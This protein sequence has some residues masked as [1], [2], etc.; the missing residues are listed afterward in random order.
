[1]STLRSD[2]GCTVVVE[3]SA[4]QAAGFVGQL[5][6]VVVCE[7][8][9]A[10]GQCSVALAGGTTPYLL[11]QNLASCGASSE[12]PWGAVNFFFGDERDVP[13]DHLE[14]NY[15]MAQ[16]ALLDHVP[17]DPTRIHPMRADSDDLA[18]AAAEYEKSIR[19]IVPSEGGLPRFDLILLGMGGDGHTASLFPCTPESLEESKR[20]VVAHFV[21]MLSR[22]RMTM[23]FPLLNAARNVVLLVTGEDKA[24][25]A[26]AL[27]ASDEAAKSH[28]PASRLHPAGKLTI[29]LDAAAARMTEYNAG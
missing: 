16:R 26:Q 15:S 9:A 20:L 28:L 18:T 10:R 21:P 14:N 8:V 27:L 5:F 11:Y 7:A 13:L 29:V 25:A 22:R 2:A 3:P 12:L 24:K 23:T 17:I 1:M 6:K 4:E 19:D